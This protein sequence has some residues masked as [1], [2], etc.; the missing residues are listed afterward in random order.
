[1]DQASKVAILSAGIFFLFGLVTGIWKYIILTKSQ[2]EKSN[3]YIHILHRTCLFYSFASLLISKLVEF[4]IFSEYLRVVLV[5]VI[6]ASFL[7]ASINYLIHAVLNDTENQFRKPYAIGKF[8]L[9]TFVFHGGMVL[10]ILEEI[11]PF[12]LILYGYIN[13]IIPKL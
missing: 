13:A 4:S 10:I 11:L 12:S 3:T 9:P 6:E 7:F 1:M 2:D 5:A 8:K